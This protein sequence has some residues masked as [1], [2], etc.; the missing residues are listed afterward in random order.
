[1]TYE[2]PKPLKL[3]KLKIETPIILAPL[4]GVTCNAFRLLCKDFGA[5]LVFSEKIEQAKY[6]GN[7]KKFNDFILEEQPIGAQIIG[8]DPKQIKN[9]IELID[10]KANVIDFNAGCSKNTYLKLKWGGWFSSHS[11]E[12]EKLLSKIRGFTDKPLTIKTRL[13]TDRQNPEIFKT[14]KVCENIGIDA[15]SVHA[16]F[17]EHNFR[18]KAD[19][20]ILREIKRQANIPV[21]ANGDISSAEDVAMVF[22]ETHCDG[23]MIGRA[24]MGN[25][26]IFRD[27]KTLL[28]EG[29]APENHCLEE[30]IQ[31]FKKFLEYLKKYN[32]DYP[33]T[34]T[35]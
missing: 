3:G 34:K 7:P 15:I 16:R 23:V 8:G 6:L 24:A 33:F 20:N 18:E 12:L 19:W 28:F 32:P 29:K 21:I 22:E 10:D 4:C 17:V 5:G 9:L 31:A 35:K 11:E 13:G 27:A 1:M 14:L 30:R 26:F 2:K 25:P